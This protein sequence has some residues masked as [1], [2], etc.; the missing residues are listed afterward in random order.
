MRPPSPCLDA[1]RRF[2]APTVSRR[3]RARGP[4]TGEACARTAQEVLDASAR[5]DPSRL[6]HHRL[7]ER[8]RQLKRAQILT[9]A[10]ATGRR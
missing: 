8:E 10:H 7:L 3:S 6:F 2:G 1:R 9:G 4:E 5:Q